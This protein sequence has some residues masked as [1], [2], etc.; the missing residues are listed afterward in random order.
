MQSPA[1]TK[2]WEVSIYWVESLYHI[3]FSKG[4]VIIGIGKLLSCCN[5]FIVWKTTN[6]SATTQRNHSS[7]KTWF[8]RFLLFT[9][10][11]NLYSM[12]VV[13]NQASE[14]S[15]PLQLKGKHFIREKAANKRNWCVRCNKMG[16]RDEVMY[17][18]RSCNVP[19]CI[20]SRHLPA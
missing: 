8:R 14:N 6:N 7:V 2:L 17:E 19:L 9:P 16:I 11:V 20:L 4:V 3:P 12:L 18:F 5:A 13:V 10:V 1:I 15:D